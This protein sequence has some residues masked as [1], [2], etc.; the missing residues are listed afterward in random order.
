MECIQVSPGLW[1][2]VVINT[3]EKGKGL[4]QLILKYISLFFPSKSTS[5]NILLNSQRPES[6]SFEWEVREWVVFMKPSKRVIGKIIHNYSVSIL[7][8]RA[9]MNAVFQWRKKRNWRNVEASL[10]K[11]FLTCFLN[12]TVSEVSTG[13][14][15]PQSVS[16]LFLVRFV[17][18]S[19]H[20]SLLWPQEVGCLVRRGIHFLVSLTRMGKKRWVKI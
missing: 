1:I 17:T 2:E 10:T 9:K 6:V 5:S 12:A 16:G 8:N 3:E 11:M 13:C 14:Q 7:E 18:T 4:S 15:P 19:V 20:H